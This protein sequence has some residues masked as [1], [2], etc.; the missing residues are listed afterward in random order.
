MRT[1]ET[2]KEGGECMSQ[3]EKESECRRFRERKEGA[4]KGQWG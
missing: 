4:W 1:L 2:A 3:R